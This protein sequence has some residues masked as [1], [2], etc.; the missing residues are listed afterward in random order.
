MV[1]LS[2]KELVFLRWMSV[3]VGALDKGDDKKIAQSLHRKGLIVITNREKVYFTKE[4]VNYLKE[5]DGGWISAIP[6]PKFQNQKEENMFNETE[7]LI[8]I[9]L[10]ESDLSRAVTI[11]EIITNLLPDDIQI[12][13][14]FHGSRQYT[15]V[16]TL[17]NKLSL[18]NKVE[19]ITRYGKATLYQLKKNKPSSSITPINASYTEKIEPQNVKLNDILTA[20]RLLYVSNPEGVTINMVNT[21]FPGTT[22]ESLRIR[23]NVLES[24]G[25]VKIK[26]IS[27]TNFIEPTENPEITI[28][29]PTL[30]SSA[31]QITR[32]RLFFCE[33]CPETPIPAPSRSKLYITSCNLC[34]SSYLIEGDIAFRLGLGI[35]IDNWHKS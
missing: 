24:E 13:N 10:T 2:E 16:Y 19:K 29:I 17:L 22:L 14:P 33:V 21:Q 26:K 25:M 1:K 4:G 34:Q 3:S 31:K 20:I 23:I 28:A 11:K 6:E 32:A 18:D 35:K 8:A 30:K 7:V 27:N 12:A 5:L 15:N 9:E